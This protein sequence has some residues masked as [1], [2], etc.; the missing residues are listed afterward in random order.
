MTRHA[1]VVCAANVCRSP[2][3]ERLLLRRVGQRTDV[4]GCSWRVGSAGVG[5]VGAPID[6]HTVHAAAQVDIDLGGHIPRALDAP[7]LSRD[8]A[9]LVLVM[10]RAQLRFVVGLDPAAWSRTF[11]LKELV[12]RAASVP[13]YHRGECL[14]AWLRRVSEGRRAADLMTPDAMDD[15]GDPYGRP[16]REHV[17]MVGDL[18]REIDALVQLGPWRGGAT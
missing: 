14:E 9:D 1:L 18:S 4:D 17:A 7:V 6:R 3:A 13:P 5:P 15:V 10:T 11:T 2:V 12:R 8:G 16:R